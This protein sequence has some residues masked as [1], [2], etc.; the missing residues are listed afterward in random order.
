MEKKKEKLKEPD[1]WTI[2]SA[3]NIVLE[4]AE[5]SRLSEDYWEACKEHLAFLCQKLGLTNVQIVVL[6]IMIEAGDTVTWKSLSNYLG[7]TRLSMMACSE[8]IEELV[9]KRW[10]LHKGSYERG[11]MMEGGYVLAQGVVTALR[12]NTTFVPEKID[13]LTEQQ[14]VDKLERHVDKNM[15]DRYADFETE[16]EWMLQLVKANP[17]LPLCR[18]VLKFDNIHVQSLL[19]LIVCDY[20]QY[21]GTDGEGLQYEVINDL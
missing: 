7:C 15:R 9:N 10:I 12:H 14:F 20:G 2:I 3:L 18:E 17:D 13:G 5:E 16:E 4:V 11:G 1:T 21:E 8:E 19:L 6:A